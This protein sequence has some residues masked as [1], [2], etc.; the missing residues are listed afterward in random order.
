MK[1]KGQ[2]KINICGFE[3]KK[4]LQT[5][6]GGVSEHP[7]QKPVSAPVKVQQV[8]KCVKSTPVMWKRLLLPTCWWQIEYKRAACSFRMFERSYLWQRR[9]FKFVCHYASLEVSCAMLSNVCRACINCLKLSC[10]LHFPLTVWSH[11]FTGCSQEWKVTL[12]NTLKY[13]T[14]T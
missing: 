12:G 14:S 10:F 11:I 3:Y 13:I 4:I 1:F 2:G 6:V 8:L 5:A 9:L 7:K